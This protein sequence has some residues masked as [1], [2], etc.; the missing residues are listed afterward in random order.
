MPSQGV[1]AAPPPPGAATVL[2]ASDASPSALPSAAT[3]IMP[4]AEPLPA[5]SSTAPASPP[6]NAADP[7]SAPMTSVPASPEEFAIG[8]GE[9]PRTLRSL[10]A[11][12]ATPVDAREG[13]IE[14]DV[15]GR[16]KTKLPLERIQAI[17]MAGVSGIAVRPILVVDLALNWTDAAHEPLKVIRFRSDQFDPRSFEPGEVNPLDALT[18]WVRRLQIRSEATCLPSRDIL[19]GSFARYDSVESYENEVLMAMRDRHDD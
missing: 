6:A 8:V 10:K 14:I 19:E 12:T 13:W 3:R 5:Q 2:E 4:N 11:L 1:Q 7:A 17:V 15:E 9:T 18:A 16:G